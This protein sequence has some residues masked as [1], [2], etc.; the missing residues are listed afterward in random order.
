N[1]DEVTRH[2]NP[3]NDHVPSSSLQDL[4]R[5]EQYPGSISVSTVAAQGLAPAIS[6]SNNALK[7][8]KGIRSDGDEDLCLR[9]CVKQVGCSGISY[10]M[11][12]ESR[13]NTNP[14]DCD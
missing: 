13:E 6:L 1:L 14:D 2:T 3:S 10:I 9:V 5:W 11:N 8:L 12:F 4:F 7:H